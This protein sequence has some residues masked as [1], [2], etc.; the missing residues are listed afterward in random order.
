MPKKKTTKKTSRTASSRVGGHIRANKRGTFLQTTFAQKVS[1]GIWRFVKKSSVQTKT[2]LGVGM[3]FIVIPLFFYVNEGIQLAYF[4]PQV[5]PVKSTYA[6]PTRIIIPSVDINLPIQE[7]AISHGVWQIAD[8]GISH[9]AISARPGENGAIILYGHNTND[10]FGPIRWVLVGQRIIITTKDGS[11]H[12]YKVVE[13]KDVSP[14]DV[15]ALIRPTKETL[16]LY[17]CDGFA[18]L[19]RFLLIA[20]PIQ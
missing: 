8:S 1:L 12:A 11:A 15:S 5:V 2:L 13:R 17:T 10:R 7:T 20:Q 16:I 9:L 14:S 3:L 4:T 6:V 18:D 19:Q